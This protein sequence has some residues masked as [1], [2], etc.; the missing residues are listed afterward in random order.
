MNVDDEVHDGQKKQ[1]AH[2]PTCDVA[3][4]DRIIAWGEPRFFPFIDERIR[5]LEN[6]GPWFNILTPQMRCGFRS[7]LESNLEE[8]CAPADLKANLELV[9]NR[10][11]DVGGEGLRGCLVHVPELQF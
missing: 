6:I 3:P 7:I 5:C 8:M 2:E 10:L 4:V 1:D 11:R 9:T